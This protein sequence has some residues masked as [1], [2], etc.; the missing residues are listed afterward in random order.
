M[1]FLAESLVSGPR[2][3]QL[4]H[5]RAD[6]TRDLLGTYDGVADDADP[7]SYFPAASFLTLAP[8]D[9]RII[10]R[11]AGDQGS[12]GQAWAIDT[13]KRTSERLDGTPVGW[14][15]D[16]TLSSP[17]LA[18]EPLVETDPSLRGAWTTT[19]PDGPVSV[20]IRRATIDTTATEPGLAT[21]TVESAGPDTIRV[22]RFDAAA[23][24]DA[25]APGTYRW[26]RDEGGLTITLVDDPCASRS[27]LLAG[28]FERELPTPD[29]GTATADAGASYV[30]SKFALP[31]SVTIPGSASAGV[32]QHGHDGVSLTKPEGETGPS[33]RISTAVSGLADPCEHHGDPITLAPGIAGV[34]AYLEGI[35]KAGL[36]IGPFEPVT[37][38]GTPGIVTTIRGGK[39]AC[40]DG[41][42]GGLSLRRPQLPR[43]HRVAP[44]SH[45]AR[46]WDR[47]G[48]HG[49]ARC[50]GRG[51]SLDGRTAGVG[52]VRPLISVGRPA[53]GSPRP[54][55][56][57]DRRMPPM[58]G[59]PRRSTARSMSSIRLNRMHPRPR[60][61]FGRRSAYG[62]RP[63]GPA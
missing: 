47:R 56:S 29:S 48:D 41:L 27:A 36:E 8:D 19:G 60:F 32:D 15:S 43:R 28:T 17:R 53:L 25:S 16:T 57:V 26:V 42:R 49:A 20:T 21:L 3:V 61:A 30:A 11:V 9:S 55:R 40:P 44:L 62:S 24:C 33:L 37:V 58:R 1:W 52:L 10:I 6:G 5:I 34:R 50:V 51:A 12:P 35:D 45:R 59:S 63:I 39:A 4:V 2:T 22:G 54:T 7:N 23:P 13:R 38:A 14:L 18:A 31:F 46:R